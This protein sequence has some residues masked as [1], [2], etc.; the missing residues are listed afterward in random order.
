MKKNKEYTM[1][2]L[3][4]LNDSYDSAGF[5]FQCLCGSTAIEDGILLKSTK[6]RMAEK[7]KRLLFL[8]EWKASYRETDYQ[9]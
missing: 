3:A 9:R 2:S 7:R 6:K 1:E 4:F 5:C 8:P